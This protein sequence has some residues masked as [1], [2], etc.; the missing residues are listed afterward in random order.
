MKTPSLGVR[1]AVVLMA[2]A[3]AAV[4]WARPAEAAAYGLF[5][6][7]N[8]DLICGY[9]CSPGQRCCNIVILPAG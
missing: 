5:R 2:L 3:A 4:L 6:N 1:V 8:G 7:L 9:E